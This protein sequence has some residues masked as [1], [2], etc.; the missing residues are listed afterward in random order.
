MAAMPLT[1][2]GK[3]SGAVRKYAAGAATALLAA[4]AGN[5]DPDKLHVPDDM[6]EICRDIDFRRDEQLREVC[7]V[8][9]RNYLAYRNLPEH[10]NLLEPKAGVIIQ[11]GVELQLRLENFLPVDLPEEFRGKLRFGENV[12][13]ETVKSKMD[14]F[15]FFAPQAE[16]PEKLIRLDI[17][18]D[19]GETKSVC[20][21]VEG[22]L[23]TQQRKTG[24]ASRLLPLDCG[25]FARLKNRIGMPPPS[26]GSDPDS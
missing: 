1:R 16:R 20:Y 2:I 24:S 21:T 8:K 15:E 18:L 23:A 25:E 3:R 12:R 13:R 17:P 4:C 26:R 14:Y 10:R 19:N 7:G 6:P 11:K 22:K 9:T 5:A